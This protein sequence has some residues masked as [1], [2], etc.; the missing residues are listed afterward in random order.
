MSVKESLI[1]LGILVVAILAGYLF[2]GG[3]GETDLTSEDKE[4]VFENGDVMNMVYMVEGG[5]FTIKNG[6]AEEKTN[7][8][9]GEAVEVKIFGEPAYGDLNGDGQDDTAVIISYKTAKGEAY[10]AGAVISDKA[11]EKIKGV[12][13]LILAEDVLPK[14]IRI[15]EGRILVDYA[16]RAKGATKDEPLI[17]ITG[18]FKVENFEIKPSN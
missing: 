10:Y 6:V 9:S 8:M 3:V 16:V 4:V 1:V 12:G 18:R 15:E 5:A 2:M 11:G 13:S 17:V 7:S 14:E